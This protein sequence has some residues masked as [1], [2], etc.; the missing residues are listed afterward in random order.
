ME[1]TPRIIKTILFGDNFSLNNNLPSMADE[2]IT[3]MLINGNVT[4]AGIPLDSARRTKYDEKKFGI[5][6]ARPFRTAAL[7][8][9]LPENIM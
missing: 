1:A 7:L 8:T 9:F 6:K 5:P 3:P 2:I 4:N